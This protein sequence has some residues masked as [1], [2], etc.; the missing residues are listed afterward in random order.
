MKRTQILDNLATVFFYI[1]ELEWG[2][3]VGDWLLERAL[4]PVT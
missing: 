2:A 3:L 4:G 1:L